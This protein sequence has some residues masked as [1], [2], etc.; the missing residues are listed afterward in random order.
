MTLQKLNDFSAT[1]EST[2]AEMK[3]TE[4]RIRDLQKQMGSTP[5]RLTTQV[6]Q[7]DDA[8]VLEHLKSTLMTWNSSALNC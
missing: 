6:R 1:L 5:D 3:A 7:S 8:Q 2:Q 4:Q